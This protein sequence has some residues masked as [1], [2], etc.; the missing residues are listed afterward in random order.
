MS[1]PVAAFTTEGPVTNMYEEAF[2]MMMK[3]VRAGP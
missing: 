2:V 1:S 3:S